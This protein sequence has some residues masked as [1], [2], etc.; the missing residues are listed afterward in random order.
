MVFFE[1]NIL[2]KVNNFLFRLLLRKKTGCNFAVLVLGFHLFMLFCT[3][4]LK[5][6]YF[7]FKRRFKND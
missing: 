2:K 7:L 3:G 6:N 4:K 5:K 1:E